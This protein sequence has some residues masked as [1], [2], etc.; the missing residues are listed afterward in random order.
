[1]GRQLVIGLVIWSLSLSGYG[2][3]IANGAHH[4]M[5]NSENFSHVHICHSDNKE[6][7]KLSSDIDGE[8]AHDWLGQ[9]VSISDNGSI[10]VIGATFNDGNDN[11]S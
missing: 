7:V 4:N 5:G 1:M 2:Y 3:S 9:S 8:S 11:K 6:R 10:V